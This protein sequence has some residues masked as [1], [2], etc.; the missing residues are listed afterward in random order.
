MK[1]Y[2][3]VVQVNALHNIKVKKI[4]IAQECYATNFEQKY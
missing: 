2:F 1:Q 3:A 4:S